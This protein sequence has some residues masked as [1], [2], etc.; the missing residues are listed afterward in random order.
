[1]PV[2]P[3]S[4]SGINLWRQSPT[5]AAAAKGGG[6]TPSDLQENN[7][8][9]PLQAKLPDPLSALQKSL[10]QGLQAYMQKLR[11]DLSRPT[12]K[13]SSEANAMQKALLKQRVE[14]LRQ[15]MM[16]V[17][18]KAS[19]RAL[20]SELARLARSLKELVASMTESAA[21][22]QMAVRAGEGQAAGESP[23]GGEG[24]E[25]AAGAADE[26]AA[27]DS[28][29]DA[30]GTGAGAAAD[31]A[32]AAAKPEEP[33]RSGEDRERQDA[34]GAAGVPASADAKQE[35]ASEAAKNQDVPQAQ[36]VDSR[37][38]LR[39][40][41][42]KGNPVASDPDIQEMKQVLNMVKAFVK[43]MAQQL[44]SQDEHKE[45][46]LREDIQKAE[47][48]LEDVDKTLKGGP[49]ALAAMGEQ[50]AVDVSA[51]AESGETASA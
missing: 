32:L 23:A 34:A 45:R 50:M 7:A 21:D 9:N 39:S 49:E 43:Q 24:A 17:H 38:A 4:P 25:P 29:A 44:K 19:L 14:A 42:M 35:A 12:Q 20:A 5:P 18:D 47:K 31:A 27:G 1:M 51:P 37:A 15:Q 28:A 13:Q 22:Q 6:A 3:S 10:N 2:I 40:M 33:T 36:A 48:S 46:G 26:Q 41:L 30:G 16:M 8:Q 11:V